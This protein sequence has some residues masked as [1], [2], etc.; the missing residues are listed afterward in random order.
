MLKLNEPVIVGPNETKFLTKIRI[1][2]YYVNL[3][4]ERGEGVLYHVVCKYLLLE[5]GKFNSS[6]D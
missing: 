3:G 4:G 5:G 6:L 1:F 2:C